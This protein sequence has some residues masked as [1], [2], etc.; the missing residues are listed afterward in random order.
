[1]L[2]IYIY[3]FIFK[4]IYLLKSDVILK[5]NGNKQFEKEIDEKF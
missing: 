4:S 3:C 2:S 5:Y 1:M